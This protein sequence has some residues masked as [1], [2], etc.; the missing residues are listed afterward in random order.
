MK[1]CCS[2]SR[3]LKDFNSESQRINKIDGKTLVG[4]NLV[5]ADESGKEHKLKIVG[6]YNTSDPI[7]TGNQI[8]IPRNSLIEFNNEVIANAKG[9]T[10]ITSDKA[11]KILVDDAKNLEVYNPRF[12]HIAN[13]IQW[14]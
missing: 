12:P 7:F 8:L 4:K 2:C 9:S 6:V 11:Y 14:T 10:S 5:F 3:I 13:R 1:K